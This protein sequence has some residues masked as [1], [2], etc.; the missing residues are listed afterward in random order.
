MKN[1]KNLYLIN[2]H[3]PDSG[4]TATMKDAFYQKLELAMSAV[5]YEDVMV[6]M[7]DFNASVGTQ[8]DA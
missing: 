3:A 6:L 7:G 4:K 1:G 5:K 8:L 2:A